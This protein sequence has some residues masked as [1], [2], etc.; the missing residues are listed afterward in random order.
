QAYIAMPLKFRN[1]NFGFTI[2]PG[3][4]FAMVMDFF[5]AITAMHHHDL[6]HGDLHSGNILLTKRDY[7]IFHPVIV[8][9]GLSKY[10]TEELKNT[11]KLTYE[12]IEGTPIFGVKLMQRCWDNDPKK[13]PGAKEMTNKVY[14]WLISES[15]VIQAMSQ[16]EIYDG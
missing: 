3:M 15:E 16:E 8:D 4:R 11:Q 12:I 2:I 9:F 1:E 14:S 13:R 10:L 5:V 6:I 7:D